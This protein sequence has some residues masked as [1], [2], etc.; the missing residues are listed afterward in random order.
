MLTHRAP[1]LPNDKAYKLQTWYTDAGRRTAS[2]TAAV[3]K[4]KGA[5]RKVT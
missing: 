5:G 3:T 2:A 4:V 1:Y